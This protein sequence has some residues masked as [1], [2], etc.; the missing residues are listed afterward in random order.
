M[1]AY[2]STPFSH[3]NKERTKLNLIIKV[4]LEL[5]CLLFAVFIKQTQ[6]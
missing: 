5:E 3:Y 4:R 6:E 2:K 1:I